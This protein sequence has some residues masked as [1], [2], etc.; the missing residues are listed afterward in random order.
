MCCEG[1]V[2]VVKHT[3]SSTLSRGPFEV[4]PEVTCS[5]KAVSAHLMRP[6]IFSGTLRGAE[7]DDHGWRG[8]EDP[9]SGQPILRPQLRRRKRTAWTATTALVALVILLLL[10]LKRSGRTA[11]LHGT[12]NIDRSAFPECNFTAAIFIGWP[13]GQVRFSIWY[14]NDL[15]YS[16][17]YFRGSCTN[18]CILLAMEAFI[19]LN[20]CLC[21]CWAVAFPGMHMRAW[22]LGLIPLMQQSLTLHLP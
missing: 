11:A 16:E 9:P 14:Q 22:V 18:L 1:S 6:V 19:W 4:E 10:Q 3:L 13:L 21:M 5:Q 8:N 20:P 7:L 15:L 12:D 2:P 17:H